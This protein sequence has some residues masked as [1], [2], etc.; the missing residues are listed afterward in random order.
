MKKAAAAI[1]L[2]VYFTVTTGF[3]VSVHYCMNKKVAVELGYS[4]KKDCDTCGM[5]KAKSKGCCKDDVRVVKMQSDHNAAKF[6]H[7]DFSTALLPAS[8]GEPAAASLFS[9]VEE[10]YPLAHGPPLSA[11]DTYLL[12]CVFRL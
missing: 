5:K 4:G 2:L 11:Q 9:S 3:T 1:L 7:P 6:V 10:D 8:F 12:N